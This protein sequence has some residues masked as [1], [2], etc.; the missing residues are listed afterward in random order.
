MIGRILI[1]LLLAPMIAAVVPIVATIPLAGFEGVFYLFFLVPAAYA[2]AIVLGLPAHLV[3]QRLG[4]TRLPHY[5]LMG[6]VLAAATA[7]LFSALV[8]HEARRAFGLLALLFG[9]PAGAIGGAVFWR[10]A[11]H[12]L[13]VAPEPNNTLVR[14]HEP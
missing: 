6:V 12:G 7:L 1:G 4:F 9:V 14:T 11:M 5:A 13:Q 3:L 8:H 10:I 2:C